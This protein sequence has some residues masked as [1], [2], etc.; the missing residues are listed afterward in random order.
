MTTYQGGKKRLGKRISHIIKLVEN[1]L[2][3]EKL[4]YFEPFVG[5]A[6]VIRH[7]SNE[8]RKLYANDI[9]KDI[10][11][12]WKAIQKGWKPPLTCTEEEYEKLKLS[13]KHSANRGFIGTV[14]SWG[15]IFFHYYRL[16]YNKNKDYIREGYNGIMK[17]K[18][19]IIDVNFID[20]ESFDTFK[21]EGFVVYCDPPYK[22]NKLGTSSSYFQT[23][24]HEHFWNIMREW[25]KNNL[26]IISE[27]T[28]PKDFKKLWSANSTASNTSGSKKYKDNLYI[29][30]SSYNNIH[31][32]TLQNI[33]NI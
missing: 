8:N 15:G 19:Y 13:K 9:N 18:P 2:Y 25:S 4:D 21:P 3:N 10:I 1:D 20:S 17:I 26:V 24:D 28:A 6:G 5:M 29:H 23:F 32:N 14:A 12:M 31:K 30:V 16:N 27:S 7:F 11:L 22:G 33:R